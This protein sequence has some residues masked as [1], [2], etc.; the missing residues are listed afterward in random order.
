M[1]GKEVLQRV[2]DLPFDIPVVICSGHGEQDISRQFLN[3]GIRGVIQKP[4]TASILIEKVTSF[5]T[6]S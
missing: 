1:G 4:Y 3:L 2:R 5:L 6:L